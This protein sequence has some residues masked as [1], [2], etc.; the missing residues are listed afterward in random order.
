MWVAMAV[1]ISDLWGKASQVRSPFKSRD[2]PR[3]A[4]SHGFAS[5]QE[6]DIG[7]KKSSYLHEAMYNASASRELRAAVCLRRLK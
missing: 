2:I 4:E 7:K 3:A 1:E 6:S 5:M